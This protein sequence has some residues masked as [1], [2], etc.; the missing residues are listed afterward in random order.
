MASFKKWQD[1]RRNPWRG[2]FHDAFRLWKKENGQSRLLDYNGL[3][4][5]AVVFDFGGFKGEWTDTVLGQQPEC[6]I[7]VFE[8]HPGFAERLV[9]KYRGDSRVFVHG[10]ALGSRDGTLRLSDAGDA[11][12]AVAGHEGGF[13]A[14]VMSVTEFFGSNEISGI[15]LA[16][17]NIEGGEYDLLPALINGGFIRRIRRLQVQFHLFEQALVAERDTIRRQLAESHDCE[18]CYPFVWEEWIRHSAYTG[19]PAS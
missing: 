19:G 16:K 4:E 10:F 18:W 8:P 13:E 15:D 7:H 5:G 11:S 2:V 12:S 6:S 17:C 1:R 3:P 9:T 14:R